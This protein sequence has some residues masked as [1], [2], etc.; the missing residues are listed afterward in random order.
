MSAL[1]FLFRYKN[2]SIKN[3]SPRNH[4]P[5]S[6]HTEKNG[7]PS[8]NSRYLSVSIEN[9]RKGSLSIKLREHKRIPEAS[10]TVEAALILPVYL[11]FII[12]FLYFFQLMA[13]QEQL[14]GAMT[15][16]GSSL[17]K[18][19]YISKTLID[20]KDMENIE[21]TF[22]SEDSEGIIRG[23]TNMILEGT[24]VKEKVRRNV[25]EASFQSSCIQGGYEG[26]SFLY[27][28]VMDDMDCI[29]II[30]RYHVKI[31]VPIFKLNSFPMIQRVKVR[32][33]TGQEVRARYKM[34]EKEK[35][36]VYITETGTVYH[37]DKNCS[38]IHLNIKKVEGNPEDYRNNAGGKYYEC[39]LCKGKGLT[40]D[41]IFYITTD[42]TRYHRI[43]NCSGIKRTVIEKELSEVADR[44]PC[45][46]CGFR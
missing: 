10:L 25:N 29:D 14:Q 21:Q 7:H 5:M 45:S 22:Q 13:L 18:Y 17:S 38:H 19:S 34:D 8:P 43:V 23:L 39:T 32:A 4:L 11:Y 37:Q 41:S 44:K 20:V 24:L 6:N 2:Q 40:G 16:V 46:R 42:G 15:E 35:E 36:L 9:S 33:W 30:A 31:P 12:A 27:S 26:I 3:L 1:L 28:T